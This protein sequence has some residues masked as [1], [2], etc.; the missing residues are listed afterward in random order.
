MVN[1][2]HI[3]YVASTVTYIEDNQA[4]GTAAKTYVHP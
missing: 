4:V 1:R 3:K 2:T